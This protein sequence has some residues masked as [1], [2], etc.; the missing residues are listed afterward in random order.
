MKARDR[1][2]RDI[3]AELLAWIIVH[4]Q[5]MTREGPLTDGA[6]RSLIRLTGTTEPSTIPILLGSLAACLETL[7]TDKIQ[8][9][10]PRGDR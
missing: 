3:A 9:D 8:Y 5:A 2:D 1:Y 6:M 10:P 7:P 4:E